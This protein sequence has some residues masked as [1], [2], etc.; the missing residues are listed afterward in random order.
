MSEF[1]K[2]LKCNGTGY[3]YVPKLTP[4]P[5]FEIC[6]SCNGKGKIK[7]QTQ[8]ATKA[9][10]KAAKKAK[11]KVLVAYGEVVPSN[12]TRIPK[13]KGALGKL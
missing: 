7:T 3:I 8:M 13:V 1:I 11:L 12:K 6:L 10:K 5:N 2:C 9:K 4:C